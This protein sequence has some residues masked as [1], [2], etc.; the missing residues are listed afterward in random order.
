MRTFNSNKI[1]LHGC[2]IELTKEIQL[3]QQKRPTSG[4]S[5]SIR[6]L[7]LEAPATTRTRKSSA[8]K[9]SSPMLT[10]SFPRQRQRKGRALHCKFLGPLKLVNT[11]TEET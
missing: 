11:R 6:L 10:T 5:A 7:Q 2:E 8:K 1:P 9:N 4:H 3:Q